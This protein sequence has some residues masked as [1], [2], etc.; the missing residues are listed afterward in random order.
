MTNFKPLTPR[1]KGD[2]VTRRAPHALRASVA[3]ILGLSVQ[4]VTCCGASVDEKSAVLNPPARSKDGSAFSSDER[5]TEDQTL[6]TSGQNRKKS[7]SVDGRNISRG[8]SPLVRLAD[9][10]AG[11]TSFTVPAI[12]PG[13]TAE[14]AESGAIAEEQ[15]TKESCDAK[16]AVAGS[17][18]NDLVVPVDGGNISAGFSPLLRL[19]GQLAATAPN[20]ATVAETSAAASD[21]AIEVAIPNAIAVAEIETFTEAAPTK[22]TC[23]TKQIVSVPTPDDLVLPETGGNIANAFSPLLRLADQLAGPAPAA[24]PNASTVVETAESAENETF[25]EAA[26]TKKS[27]DDKPAAV[28]AAQ[29]NLV[30]PVDGGNIPMGFSPLVRLAD[31]LVAIAAGTLTNATAVAEVVEAEDR[32]VKDGCAVPPATPNPPRCKRAFASSRRRPARNARN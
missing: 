28:I 22:E 18:P 31:Q 2:A 23:E 4:C 5:R 10:I 14:Y 19:A 26:P 15:P 32:H 30:I 6:Q 21:P 27:C 3:A 20:A 7:P 9:Q 16:P 13:E 25:A 12:A 24:I 17:T 29:D 11:A 1:L 8:L